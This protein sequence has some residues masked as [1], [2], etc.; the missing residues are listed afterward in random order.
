MSAKQIGTELIVHRIFFESPPKQISTMNQSSNGR[1]P[2]LQQGLWLQPKHVSKRHVEF[3]VEMSQERAIHPSGFL[4]A[5][6]RP[7]AGGCLS[8]T[9]VAMADKVGAST[10][11]AL[12]VTLQD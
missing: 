8:A 12:G 9:C 3:V 1:P 10:S 7:T 11:S 2:H 6:S 4:S 5:F